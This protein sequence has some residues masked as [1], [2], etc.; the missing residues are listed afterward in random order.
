[1]LRVNPEAHNP[2]DYFEQYEGAYECPCGRYDNSYYLRHHEA[3]VAIKQSVRPCRIYCQLCKY[4]CCKGAPY[5]AH[6]MAGEDIEGVVK[7]GS[8]HAPACNH[9]RNQPCNHA[10]YNSCGHVNKS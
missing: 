1:M 6:A 8:F 4:P 2:V 7:R 3:W 9:I 5:S 10:N